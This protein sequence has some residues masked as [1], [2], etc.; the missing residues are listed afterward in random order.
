MPSW[1]QMGARPGSLLNPSMSCSYC[2]KQVSAKFLGLRVNAQVY[3]AVLTLGP[4]V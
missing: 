1:Q 4:R 3:V 2:L